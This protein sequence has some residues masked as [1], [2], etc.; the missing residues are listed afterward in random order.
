[1]Q[2]LKSR[3]H[4]DFIGKWRP[5]LLISSLLNL[6]VLASLGIFGLNLGVDFVGGTLVEVQFQQPID[7]EGVRTAAGKGGLHDP[8]VQGVG[9]S[10]DRSFL[11]R[12]GGTTQ[13]TAEAAQKAESGLRGLGEMKFVQKPDLDN[14]VI[15]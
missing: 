15:T 7:A 9:A 1:M 8:Q 3:T 10:E 11:L 4:I 6:A 13:L 12:V 2:V 5:A 14:G